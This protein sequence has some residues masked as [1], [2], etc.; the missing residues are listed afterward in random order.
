MK[1]NMTT[2]NPLKL[3]IQFSIPLLLGNLFQQTYNMVDTAI[4]GQTL[5]ANALA[6]VGATSSVQ[7]LVL[8]FCIG[9]CAGFAIPIA[10][11]FGAKDYDGMRHHLY[12]GE[13]WAVIITATVTIVTALLCTQILQIL[14]VPEEIFSMS[15]QYLIVIFLGIPC[16]ILYNYL[17]SVL[18]AIGDSKTPFLFLAF[19]AVLN[20]ILDFFCILVLKWG[21]AGAAIATIF[22]QG[23]SGISCWVLIKKKFDVLH[24]RKENRGFDGETSKRLLV[25]AIPMGLQYSITAIGSMVMQSANNSLGTIYVSGFTAGMK[26]K[27]FLI[28]VFDSIATAVSTFASQNYGAGKMDRVKKGVFQGVMLGVGYGIVSGVLMM[29]FGR[30]LAMVFVSAEATDVLGAA[31]KYMFRMGIFWWSLGILNV[32]RMTVQGLGYS[33]RAMIGGVI[34]MINRSVVALF[35]VPLFGYNAITFAD[36]TAWV[37][38]AIYIIP[39]YLITLKN[40]EMK[41]KQEESL[42]RLQEK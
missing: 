27:Q 33:G 12:V 10:Q 34:E 17:S 35:F 22:S 38:A 13:I 29:F 6:S 23:V 28:C 9:V 39:V 2:G 19:S 14:Q 1:G 40:V 31:Q 30:Y 7:F 8:G 4:V 37:G 20:I 15:Y 11:R 41:L 16:T 25:M 26:V 18:R 24:I 36:Q 32:L 3:I 21:V 5:G 42:A